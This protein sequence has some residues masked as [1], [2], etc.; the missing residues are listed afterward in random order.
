[1]NLNEL[2][3]GPDISREFR[4]ILKTG[5]AEFDNDPESVKLL[6][7]GAL[8]ARE[9]LRSAV[10]AIDAI[11]EAKYFANDFDTTTEGIDIVATYPMEFLDGLTTLTLA[12]NWNRTKVDRFNPRTIDAKKKHIIEDGRPKVR[13]T[14]TAD[15][16]SGPWQILARL[17]YYGAHVD[18]AGAGLDDDMMKAEARTLVDFEAA[19]SF[20]DNFAFAVGAENLFDNDPT[21]HKYQGSYGNLYPE[22]T[23]FD[24]NGGFYYAKAMLNF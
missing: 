18:Y 23:P 15:H 11:G 3:G 10:P 21:R 5:N 12:A 13:W 4:H 19:Y 7:L 17:R 9:D 2:E 22:S 16:E 14:F 8:A 6:M 24:F 20:T 1:M